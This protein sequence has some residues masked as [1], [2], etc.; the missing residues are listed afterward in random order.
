M[1][2]IV[3]SGLRCTVS[4][5]HSLTHSFLPCFP[6]V[7][8]ASEWYG[9]WFSRFVCSSSSRG[10]RLTHSASLSLSLRRNS[11]CFTK[12]LH[13]P[14][15]AGGILGVVVPQLVVPEAVPLAA[16][17]HRVPQGNPG[18]RHG[19]LSTLGFVEA[20]S[21]F[22]G[23]QRCGCGGGCSCGGGCGGGCVGGHGQ[24]PVECL[25]GRECFAR[26][27]GVVEEELRLS[28]CWRIPDIFSGI[29]VVI[30][31]VVVVV[32]VSFSFQQQNG[33]VRVP[34]P[35]HRM[36]AEVCVGI[37]IGKSRHGS[38]PGH[39]DHPGRIFPLGRAVDVV[40]AKH[41]FQTCLDDGT[42]DGPL[43]GIEGILQG[44]GPQQWQRQRQ[45]GCCCY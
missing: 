43:V 4:L 42:E 23:Q 34:G 18:R 16:D 2:R 10:R 20:E 38:H 24:G 37:E 14:D 41:S 32:V 25:P 22:V 3:L 1:V 45:W 36:D 12:G 27:H 21:Q 17:R 35:V 9:S 30:L 33:P 11:G 5:T 15:Q 44:Y 29:L 8:I 28:R 26:R 31:V 40:P 39:G 13:P 6:R 19:I 7:S